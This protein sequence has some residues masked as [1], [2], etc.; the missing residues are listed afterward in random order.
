MPLL[1]RT[2]LTTAL[3]FAL[4]GTL[5]RADQR[6]SVVG[7]DQYSV[8][9]GADRTDIAY[10]GSEVLVVE[11]AGKTRRYI[12]TVNYT[13][14]DDAGK[15]ILHARFVQEM[16]PDG[17]FVDKQD[18]DP[19]FLTVLNQP[20]AV[21]LDPTTLGDL[22]RLHGSVPFRAVSPLG[23]AQ[24]RGYLRSAPAGLVGGKLAIG[25]RFQADGPMDGTLPDHPGAVLAG[26]MHID[27]TAYY[28]A[29]GALLVSLDATLT[30]DGSLRSD[31]AAVPVTITYR[32]AIAPQRAR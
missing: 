24:L 10:M 14:S 23:G 20:F 7:D 2:V 11:H 21:Q 6:Y 29:H 31:R 22:Q 27:G 16:E 30:I 18:D 1:F 13:R 19:D 26:T 9:A 8:G 5:A 4:A 17:S 28:A 25:V 3:I 32:R 15:A 12:A